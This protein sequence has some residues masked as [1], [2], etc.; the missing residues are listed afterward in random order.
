MSELVHDRV[1]DMA[2][3]AKSIKCYHLFVASGNEFVIAIGCL[4]VVVMIVMVVIMAVPVII[5][6]V[7][8]VTVVVV[9]VG[10]M[11]VM[12]VTMAAAKRS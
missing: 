8:I 2:S 9:T 12:T 1:S 3:W 4:D 11:S 5:M 6:A 10:T 7:I